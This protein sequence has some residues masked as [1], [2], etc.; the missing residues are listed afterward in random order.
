MRSAMPSIAD[1][2]PR[3]GLWPPREKKLDLGGKLG[4]SGWKVDVVQKSIFV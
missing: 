4:G 2:H 1:T 3:K